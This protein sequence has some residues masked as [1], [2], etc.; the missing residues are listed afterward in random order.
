VPPTLKQLT[1]LEIFDSQFP[2]FS[3]EQV[4]RETIALSTQGG[5]CPDLQFANFD[6]LL[7]KRTTTLGSP[8][9]LS[10]PSSSAISLSLATLSLETNQGIAQG[11]P[12]EPRLLAPR[13]AWTPSPSS[14]RGRRWWERRVYELHASS[15]TQAVS[16]LRQW[17]T[18]HWGEEY[19]RDVISLE[20]TVTSW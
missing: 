9:S 13:M 7:W 15:Q 16:L 12:H 6:G 11:E 1:Y 19:M 5:P 2:Q 4:V 18:E 3:S 20:R 17:M 10:S 8:R 14:K